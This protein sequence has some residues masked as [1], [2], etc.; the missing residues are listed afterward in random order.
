[1]S[2]ENLTENLTPESS[3]YVDDVKAFLQAGRLGDA[4]AT[5]EQGLVNSPK[6]TGLL[7]LLAVCLRYQG[8]SD[9]ALAVL[10]QLQEINPEH[11]RAWQERGH[12][13]RAIGDNQKAIHLYEKAISLNPALYASWDALKDLYNATGKPAQSAQAKMEYKR[14]KSLPPELLGV[15]GLIHEGRLYKAEQACRAY[16]QQHTKHVEG[17]RLLAQIGMKLHILDDAEFLLESCL[18]FERDYIPACVDYIHVLHRRQKYVE[19]LQ[20]A[21]NLLTRNPDNLNFKAIYA[22]QCLAVGD[23]DTSIDIYDE[24][25]KNAPQWPEL[26]LARGHALKT[27][28]KTELAV[29]SYNAAH[30]I[31][32]GYGD[33][34]WSLANLKT[35]HFSDSELEMMQKSEAEPETTNADRIH[36]CFALGKALEDSEEFKLSFHYYD[37]GNSLH[38][39]Q[40]RYRIE[41]TQ[42]SVDAQ[43]NICTRELFESRPDQGHMAAESIFIVGLPRSGSTLLEQI[44]ASHSRI[45][46]T[47]ELHNILS[48]AHRLSGRHRVNQPARYP[49]ILQELEPGQL[50]QFGEEYINKTQFLRSG[51]DFFIDKMPNNF[52]HIGLIHSILP[53]AR[54]IDARRE[55]MACCF[56][57]FKQLFGEGQAFTYGLKEIGSYYCDYVRLIK[58]WDDV[59]PGKI[60]RVQYE[61]VVTDLENQVR[62]IFD[63]LELPFEDKCL[64]FHQTDR[65]IRT[66]SS[67]QVRQP[68]YVKGLEQWK[69]YENCLGTL[70]ETLKPV[71]D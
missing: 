46:A 19:A 9:E 38:R 34:W 26:Y 31:K 57:N 20:Q 28:G 6:D 61:D 7:Y 18:E 25:L 52:I 56:S 48:L 66:P 45:D 41:Q 17:M 44:L 67:E 14:L 21:R 65:A 71:L 2:A 68:I 49:A 50:Q 60:L 58:H 8:H 53:N 3:R 54:I 33:A 32:P 27:V 69:H 51:A 59:L 1:M 37:R 29:E 30:K 62:R 12:N 16:L 36:L 64:D 22:H 43:I 70:R 10:L 63:F 15:Y 11:A 39:Q 24:L 55:P 5:A 40:S 47:M 35:Y 13:Y 42:T 23:D 4:Q